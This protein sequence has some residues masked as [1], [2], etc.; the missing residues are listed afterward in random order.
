M[1]TEKQRKVLAID[2]DPTNLTLLQGLLRKMDLIPLLGMMPEK[3]IDLAQREQPDII[4]LDIMMPDIDGYEV[5][6][7]LKADPQTAV[8]PVLFQTAKCRSDDIIRGL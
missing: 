7:R 8:I 2:D 4:L 1:K 6:R 3:G 5:C